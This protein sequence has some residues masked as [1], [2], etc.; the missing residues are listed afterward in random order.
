[1]ISPPE[2]VGGP[3]EGPPPETLDSVGGPP[4]PPLLRIGERLRDWRRMPWLWALGGA[5]AASALWAG[6]LYAFGRDEGPDQRG[7]RLAS[8][9][10]AEVPLTNLRQKLGKRDTT[11]D[12]ADLFEDPALNRLEC[13]MSIR[14]PSERRERNWRIGTVYLVTLHVEQHRRTDPGPEIEALLKSGRR[15]WGGFETE[16]LTPVG[17]LGDRAFF[18]NNYRSGPELELVAQDGG[19]LLTLRVYG[20]NEVKG[21]DEASAQ[22]MPEIPEPALGGMSGQMEADLREA[23]AVLKR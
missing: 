12:S 20:Q 22:G 6:G 3:D 1:M 14:D 11:T 10:C 17:N 13:R 5:V 16:R 8:D 18:V 23:M 2:L 21:E 19:V 4:R 15:G 9:R 7:Y